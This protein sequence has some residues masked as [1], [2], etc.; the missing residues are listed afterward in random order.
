M[1]DATYNYDTFNWEALISNAVAQ[2]WQNSTARK[3]GDDV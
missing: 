3:Q 1:D 2:I